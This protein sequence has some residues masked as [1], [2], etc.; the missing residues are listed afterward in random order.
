MVPDE[1]WQRLPKTS[2]SKLDPLLP[3][4][5]IAAG[6]KTSDNQEGVGLDQ[7]KERIGKFLRARRPESLK[8]DGKLP[9]IVGHALHDTV[10]FGAKGVA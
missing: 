4:T 7:K 10:D 2:A 5:R 6:M 8:D 3:L 1:F 9:G